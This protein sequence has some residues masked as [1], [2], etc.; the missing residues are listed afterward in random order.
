MFSLKS[1]L[2]VM[3]AG[4]LLMASPL[5]AQDSKAILDALVRKGV[6]SSDEADAIKEEAKSSAPVF[7]VGGKKVSKL[8][9][10]A[11][12]QM[13][14]AG[15]S[16]DIDGTNNDPASTNHFFLRRVYLTTKASLGPDWSMNITYDPA[17]QAF[18][19]ALISYGG[20]DLD[21]DIGL[22]KVGFGLEETTS[23]SKLKAIERSGVTRYFVESNNGRRLGAGSYRVGVFAEGKSGN[24][25]YGGA[26][27]NP[28]RV[29]DPTSGGNSG[30]NNMAY[31]ANAGFEGDL[32][33]GSFAFGAALGILPDQGGKTVGAG[34][35]M[36]AYSI[37]GDVTTGNFH[38]MAEY[39]SAKVDN[40]A[41]ATMDATPSGYWVQGAFK[42]NKSFEGVARFSYLDTDGRGVKLSDGVRS[43]P[44]GNTNDKLTEYFVGGSWY[45]IGN[46][47]KFQAGYVY[48]KSEDGAASA[49]TS[50]IRSQMQINF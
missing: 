42:F 50:G 7:A 41:S 28:E 49:T 45:I 16:T 31:W 38:L 48:G 22:R 46:D 11:R 30:N 34:D 43:A 40:G 29:G 3:L 35:D 26:I 2:T 20:S 17:N 6:L 24:F 23:S 15:L 12:I 13:Q 37:Y 36:T 4:L 19:K 32:A 1:K 33:D 47:L 14:Y 9:L 18:D 44:A 21:I 25:V 39:M 10:G 27:T 8:S 5:A